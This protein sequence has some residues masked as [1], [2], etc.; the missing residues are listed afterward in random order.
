MYLQALSFRWAA[1]KDP[2][3]KRLAQRTARALRRLQR[4]TRT[5]GCFAR[6]FKRADGLTWDEQVFFFPKEW[7]QAGRYRWLGDPSTDSLVG[8]MSGYEQYFDLVADAREKQEVAKDVDIIMSRIVDNNMRIV[9]LDGRMT[10]WGNMCPLILEENLN[11]LEAL[12]HLRA[13]YHLSKKR[14]YLKEYHRLIEQY[15]YHKKAAVANAQE[16][17]EPAAWDWN[18]ATS[19]L[20]SLL[21]YEKDPSLL[22]Y[23]YRALENQ[24]QGAYRAGAHDAFFNWVYKVFHPRA[25]IRKETWEW[26]ESVQVG[27]QDFAPSPTPVA[28]EPMA[29]PRRFE[30]V[31]D[32][33]PTVI[34]GAAEGVPRSFLRAYWM[35]RY[36]GFIPPGA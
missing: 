22:R 19:P 29:Q 31:V 16:R 17:F 21:R 4:V 3:A 26:L 27:A 13:A 20:Y 5:K 6:G 34:E 1:T 32:G 7:H 9:D 18:L 25:P 35:G 10:L 28:P 23:Y 11:A 33:K 15:H 8:I 2:K 14:R 30:V 36:Y 24:W 12:S